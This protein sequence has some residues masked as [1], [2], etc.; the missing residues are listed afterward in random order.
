MKRLAL[1]VV[2]LLLSG[3]ALW[4]GWFIYRDKVASDNSNKEVHKEDSKV[5]K[6]QKTGSILE[7]FNK[8]GVLF[9]PKDIKID[10]DQTAS[11]TDKATR[12]PT[13]TV[14]PTV[15]PREVTIQAAIRIEFTGK[16]FY[17]P[18][19]INLTGV[20]RQTKVITAQ[21]VTE[22][23]EKVNQILQQ[24]DSMDDITQ[25]K[26]FSPNLYTYGVYYVP[27]HYSRLWWLEQNLNLQS[28]LSKIENNGPTW[29]TICEK[30]F[31]TVDSNLKTLKCKREVYREDVGDWYHTG[32]SY[33]CFIKSADS[34][35]WLVSM[36]IG[37]PVG[38]FYGCKW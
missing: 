9:L 10:L 32:D 18:T 26:Y 37:G 33:V 19:N 6:K 2:T 30:T 8:G 24:Y 16:T 25:Y 7:I 22:F 21:S 34:K 20:K 11:S 3:L 12:A 38:D 14:T 5:S 13:K 1:V 4:G 27:D 29:R 28:L 17:L 36:V 31:T 35:S 23:V 15:I